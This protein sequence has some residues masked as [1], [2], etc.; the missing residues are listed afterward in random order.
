MTIPLWYF[1]IWAASAIAYGFAARAVQRA[2]RLRA[3]PSLVTICLIELL[4]FD[5]LGSECRSRNYPAYVRTYYTYAAVLVLARIWLA[6][7]VF[8][9]LPGRRT[10][11]RYL[12]TRVLAIAVLVGLLSAV[13]AAP[14]AQAI[15]IYALCL[16]RCFLLTWAVVLVCCTYGLLTSG[17]GFSQTSVRIATGAAV[18][19]ISSMTQAEVFAGHPSHALKMCTTTL[20]TLVAFAIAIYWCRA[21]IDAPQT[22]AA[23]RVAWRR[24]VANSK[25]S[26]EYQCT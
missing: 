6:F 3:W 9:S 25:P 15:Q 13:Y 21:M 2:G 16:N 4:S 26:E 10:I 24:L 23:E 7:D 14:H 20:D 18:R 11:P 19:H 17:Y 8:R 22:D 5:A 1:L 12:R